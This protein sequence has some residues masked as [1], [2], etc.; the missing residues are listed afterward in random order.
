MLGT[1]PECGE[2]RVQRETHTLCFSFVWV[3]LGDHTEMLKGYSRLYT[4]DLTPG[5]ALGEPSGM[6][7]SNL[8]QACAKQAPFQLCYCSSPTT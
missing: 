8:G 3:L 1:G 2:V 7:G 5:R 4:Q 6:W